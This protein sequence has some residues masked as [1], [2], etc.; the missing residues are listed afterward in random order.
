MKNTRLIRYQE[1][2]NQFEQN[3]QKAQELTKQARA[4]EE[5]FDT[6][7]VVKLKE[8]KDQYMRISEEFDK[9]IHDNNT[10]NAELAQFISSSNQ[11]N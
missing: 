1:L 6:T 3:N 8:I 5:Q 7:D 11:N 9:I 2:M 10:I 4:L